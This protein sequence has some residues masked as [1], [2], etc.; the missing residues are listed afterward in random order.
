MRKCRNMKCIAVLALVLVS[1]QFWSCGSPQGDTDGS[2]T[3]PRPDL[4]LAGR[5]RVRR[6][7]RNLRRPENPM[8]EVQEGDYILENAFARYVIGR[9][10]RKSPAPFFSGSVIDAHLQGGNECLRAMVPHPGRG[11][12]WGVLCEDV[13][14]LQ[15]QERKERVGVRASGSIPRYA[16]VKVETD[17]ILRPGKPS[18]LVR[19]RIHNTGTVPVRNLAL[20]DIL[21]PGQTERFAERIGLH[22]A[23]EQ[24]Q[25]RWLSCFAGQ[26]NWTLSPGSAIAMEGDHR[27]GHSRLQYSEQ[28]IMPGRTVTYSRFLT[29]GYGPFPADS[30]PGAARPSDP[31]EVAFE[32]VGRQIRRP[33]P[34]AYIELIS[35]T[36]QSQGLAVTDE[37]GAASVVVPAGAYRLV[38]R[39]EGRD[40]FKTRLSMRAKTRQTMRI[41]LRKA[42]RIRVN[43]RELMEGREVPTPARLTIARATLDVPRLS[44]IP[45]HSALGPGRTVLVPAGGTAEF[46]L[47]S[48]SHT[49]PGEYFIAASKGPAYTISSQKIAVNSGEETTV[50]LRLRRTVDRNELATVDFYQFDRSSPGSTLGKS[51]RKLLN[52]TEDLDWGVLQDPS[53]WWSGTTPQSSGSWFATAG[54]AWTAS[55]GAV[56]VIFA[57]FDFHRSGRPLPLPGNWGTSPTEVFGLL[58]RYLPRSMLNVANPLD[59]HSGYFR[60]LGLKPGTRLPPSY[61]GRFDGLVVTATELQQVLPRWFTLLEKGEQCLLLAGS[62]SR[63]IS[64]APCMAARTYVPVSGGGINRFPDLMSRLPRSFVST[65]PLVDFRIAGKGP[66]N[67][68]RITDD[69]AEFRVSVRAPRWIPVETVQIYCNGEVVRTFSPERMDT[70]FRTETAEFPVTRDSW[71]VVVVSASR[72]MDPLYLDDQGAGIPAMAVTNPI[73]LRY[74]DSEP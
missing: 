49:R 26:W 45:W 27:R 66:G 52:D 51:G 32:V 29:P 41:P 61:S 44:E 20:A 53:S 33:I 63:E 16:G 68:V 21:Y 42:G 9:A 2:M 30:A 5:A 35:D 39:A 69:K 7:D 15:G 10:G 36:R 54:N 58:R 38:C 74:I 13:R 46:S 67:V 17:Y 23:G 40:A 8:V 31:V 14:V 59:S 55:T 3:G 70:R 11:S 43:V 57:D 62:G 24:A 25:S 56:S 60:Q 1:L 71:V 18:L 65:G 47:P 28:T 22:P 12:G 4:D 73:W 64:D 6:A 19:T 48:T 37:K 50:N 34:G 72:T